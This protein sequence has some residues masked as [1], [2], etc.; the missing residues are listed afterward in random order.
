MRR[1]LDGYLAARRRHGPQD[2]RHR[3]EHIGRAGGVQLGR[4]LAEL[5][6][7]WDVDRTVM[8][9]FPILGGLSASLG[10]RGVFKTRRAN[11]WLYLFG[12]QMGFMLMHS[13][14]G[15]CPPSAVLRR[16]GYRTQREISRER[17]ALLAQAATPAPG[18]PAH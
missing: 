18:I 17:H 13:L 10:V 14:V 9:L 4:R 1:T 5:D 11:G 2:T 15:W 3:I 6:R 12:V 7:E 16:M 8:T